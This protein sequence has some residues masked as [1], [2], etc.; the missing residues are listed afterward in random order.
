MKFSI[1]IISLLSTTTAALSTPRNEQAVKLPTILEEDPSRTRDSGEAQPAPHVERA[2][3]TT[4]QAS[5]GSAQFCQAGYPFLCDGWCCQLNRC[6]GR[7]CCG[8]NATFCGADGLC[9]Y[10]S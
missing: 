9:Y 4:T 3:P 5:S 7:E 1:T 6:C 8:P 10:Y 2:A